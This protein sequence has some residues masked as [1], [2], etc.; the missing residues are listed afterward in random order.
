MTSSS[1]WPIV[2]ML[3]LVAVKHG[4]DAT[5]YRLV[6]ASALSIAMGDLF[7]GSVFNMSVM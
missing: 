4:S 6:A 1:Q 7:T 2:N 3:T 5:P